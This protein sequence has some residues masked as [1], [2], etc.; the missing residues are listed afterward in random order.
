MSS[1]KQSPRQFLAFL[2][3]RRGLL[4][5]GDLPREFLDPLRQV[6]DGLPEALIFR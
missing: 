3:S 5:G 4:E 1:G 2:M 6:I